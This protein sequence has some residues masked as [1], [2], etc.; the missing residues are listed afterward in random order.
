[1]TLNRDAGTSVVIPTISWNSNSCNVDNYNDLRVAYW[2]SGASQWKS[3]GNDS[4][5]A[6]GNR[7]FIFAS[8]GINA[9][10]L[11]LVPAKPKGQVPYAILSRELDGGYVLVN[12]GALKFKFDEEYNDTDDKLKMRIINVKFNT[13]VLNN[14]TLS[15]PFQ[16]SSD[17]GERF[18]S[19]NLLNCAYGNLASGVYLLEVSNEKNEKWYLRFKHNRSITTYC[20]H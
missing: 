7:G 16:L 10:L 15:V 20:P 1:Y 3:L 19:V 14:A 18:Y 8:L 4:V 2:D 5:Y 9:T 13:E 17:Y 11:P 6:E 12:N